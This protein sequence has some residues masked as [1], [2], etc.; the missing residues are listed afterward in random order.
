VT[1]LAADPLAL[2]RT[3][4]STKWVRYPADV[5]PMFV[6]EMDYPLAPPIAAKLVELV[7]R[8]DLGYDSRRPDLGIA[9]AD[10]AKDAWDWE[11]DPRT[12]KWTVNVMHAITEIVRTAIEPGD[13]VVVTTPVYP[14]FF[15]AATESG[16]T[17]VEVPLARREPV[18]GGEPNGWGLDLEAIEAAF[19]D[20]ARVF[21]LC[22]PHNPVGFPHSRPDLERLAE[23]A[24]QYGVLVVSD[25]IH[26]ALTH[27]D[28]EFIPY[29]AISDAARE[30]GVCVTSASK[31]FNIPALTSAWWI[32]GSKA[33]GERLKGLPESLVHR[34]SHFGTHASTVGFTE[35]RGWLA[36]V[37]ETLEAR[38]AQLRALVDEHMPEAV[39]HEPTASYLAWIDFRP[40]G[41]GDDPA[42]R[43]LKEARIALN[44][45]AG[46]GPGGK[47]FARIT[48]ACAPDVL[49][50]AIT[51]IA[52][53]R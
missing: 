22:H 19:R 50:D 15:W 35:G 40:L 7:G 17:L 26:G 49:E 44:P 36:D 23:L 47:G 52:A 38:R 3:R 16:G 13:K 18:P 30:T 1:E 29:L 20:G 11:F 48:F 31:A 12:L 37:V 46:F 27:S 24:A 14:P 51:R 42:R 34:V 6:A 41:W 21:L 43:I 33:V 9:F 25:E 4:T 45:G 2:L 32:P 28:A 5:L 10:F 53:L 39:L 8:S